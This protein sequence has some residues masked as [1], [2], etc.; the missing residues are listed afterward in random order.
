VPALVS[1]LFVI[2]CFLLLWIQLSEDDRSAKSNIQNTAK[3]IAIQVEST[4]DQSESI[5][6]TIGSRYLEMDLSNKIELNAFK[7][8]IKEEIGHL[9]L[10]NLSLLISTPEGHIKLNTST[11]ED[12]FRNKL[13]PLLQNF[14]PY[15]S[16][17]TSDFLFTDPIKTLPN[18]EW[19]IFGGRFQ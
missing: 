4:L 18:S 2:I 15:L 3:I 14:L 6:N 7:L 10:K 1:L 11:D 17:S 13:N 5:M 19:S 16:N 8:Q 12:H 9:P